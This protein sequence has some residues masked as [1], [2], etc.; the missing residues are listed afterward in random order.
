MELFVFRSQ[1]EGKK[2]PFYLY[3]ANFQCHSSSN[4]VN[5]AVNEQI[6]VHYN[7]DTLN[8]YAA[9]CLNHALVV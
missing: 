4:E 9:V 2:L 1:R 5:K 7:T 3:A 6:M 8:K